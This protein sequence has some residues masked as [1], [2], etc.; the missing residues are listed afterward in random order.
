VLHL[1]LRLPALLLL[2]LLLLFQTLQAA[3]T[4][5]PDACLSF[6]GVKASH[7]DLLCLC[8]HRRG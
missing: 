2:V 4:A 3:D 7:G 8:L 6:H 1:L 5:C